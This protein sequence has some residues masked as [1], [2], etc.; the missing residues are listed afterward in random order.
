M[1]KVIISGGGTGGHVFPAIAIA[2]AIKARVA[3]ADILFIGAK[4]KMEMEKVPAAGYPIHGLWISGLQR[5]LTWKNLGF[6]FKVISS[7]ITAG[8]IISSFKP[9]VVI[10]V[11]GYAS[12][13][14]LRTAVRK[15]IPTL[16]QE[17]NSFPGITNKLLAKK[18]NKICVAYDGMERFF[19][20][21]KILFTGNPVRQDIFNTGN[22]RKEGLA[23][24]GLQPGKKVILILGGS[25]GAGTI[26]RSALNCLKNGITT[27]GFQ[28]LWQTGRYYFDNIMANNEASGNADVRIQAFIDRM[29]LAY[30]SA[31]IVISRAGAIAI[32]ELC[33]AGKPA[34]LIPS[35]NVAEDH[36][37]KNAKSLESKGA[38]IMIPDAEAEGSVFPALIRLSGDEKLR[39][40]LQDNIL[41]L[42]MPDAAD[43]IAVEALQLTGKYSRH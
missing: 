11:G 41:K 5:R 39:N 43:R 15:K 9:D 21:E 36:Q 30:A 16:I 19:P 2:N 22:K 40:S 31:D 37:A 10:G 17:Q 13:P 25:L 14:T 35:P 42:A 23:Y 34:I 4:G 38:A 24:F 27:R 26:N 1:I 12:G 18:V 20:K 6:P 29:D 28:L 33:I 7:L 8:K 3:D 32:S